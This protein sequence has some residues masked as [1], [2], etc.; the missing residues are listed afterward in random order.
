MPELYYCKGFSPA[1]LRASD[2][3]DAARRRACLRGYEVA[4]G[5]CDQYYDVWMY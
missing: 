2:P 5:R 1:T 4:G 3:P